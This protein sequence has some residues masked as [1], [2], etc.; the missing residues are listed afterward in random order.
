MLILSQS[1]A[2]IRIV[3]KV[4]FY[5][6]F[7]VLRLFVSIIISAAFF[8]CKSNR[9]GPDVSKVK[10]AIKVKRFERDFFGLDTSNLVQGLTSLHKKDSLAYDIFF[11]DLLEMS[12]NDSSI[13]LKNVKA[14][15][16][17]KY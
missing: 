4:H 3:R 7:F 5:L 10:A 1:K 16:T 15:L 9:W 6:G 12:T 14:L 11:R 17:D 13:F 2:I 8:S